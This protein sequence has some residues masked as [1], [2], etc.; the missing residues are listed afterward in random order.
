[1]A[2]IQSYL[3]HGIV[4][5]SFLALAVGAAKDNRPIGVN[6]I[7]EFPQLNVCRP[8]RAKGLIED[9]IRVWFKDMGPHDP[10]REFLEAKWMIKQP[11]YRDPNYDEYQDTLSKVWGPISEAQRRLFE[12]EEKERAGKPQKSLEELL[13]EEKAWKDNDDPYPGK[14]QIERDEIDTLNEICCK[15]TSH[16]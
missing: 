11:E 2:P 13:E 14:E 12:E 6:Q 4:F 5:S 8:A 1:M 15:F 16:R 7:C 3:I 10:R 9:K